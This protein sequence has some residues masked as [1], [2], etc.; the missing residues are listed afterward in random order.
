[1][2]LQQTQSDRPTEGQGCAIAAGALTISFFSCVGASVAFSN[3][4]GLDASGLGQLLAMI[5]FVAFAV[6]VIA[7]IIGR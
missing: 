2:A 3:A 1:M 6:A 5:G 4:K 7:A